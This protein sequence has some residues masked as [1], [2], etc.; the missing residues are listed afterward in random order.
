M[1]KHILIFE[2]NLDIL[3]VLKQIFT[4]EGYQV[5]GLTAID[6]AIKTVS[7]HKPD[8]VITDYILDG[9]NGGEYCHQIKTNSATSHIPVMILSGYSVLLDSLGDYGADAIVSKPFDVQ[10]LLNKVQELL[11]GQLSAR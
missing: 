8:L 4:D 9:I 1:E 10:D 3:D 2:D 11:N 5:T 7:A 6:D